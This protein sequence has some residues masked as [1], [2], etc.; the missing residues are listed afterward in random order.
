M[1]EDDDALLQDEPLRVLLTAAE[2][3]IW[4]DPRAG[5]DA[6]TQAVERARELSQPAVEARARFW[7]AWC[8]WNLS[9]HPECLREARET[10]KAF[11]ELDHHE[12]QAESLNLLGNIYWQLADYAEALDFYDGAKELF[13][14]I[15]NALGQVK[16]LRNIAQVEI[17]LDDLPSA[18]ARARQARTAAESLNDERYLIAALNI[19]AQSLIEL[20][21]GQGGARPMDTH[22]T[23]IEA[24]RTLATRALALSRQS[25]NRVWES[26]CLMILAK[27]ERV[28][29]RLAQALATAQAGLEVAEGVG[30]RHLQ[31][32]AFITIG[33]LQ[34]LMG[35]TETGIATL[36]RAI[37]IADE[38]QAKDQVSRICRILSE[39]YERAGQPTEALAYSRRHAT[40]QQLVYNEGAQRRA[41]N[42][43]E[44]RRSEELLR[45]KLRYREQ[46]RQRE[47]ELAHSARLAVAGEMVSWI[48]H[49]LNQPH[50]AILSYSQ[51]GIG[52]IAQERP[53]LDKIA[54]LFKS[55]ETQATRADEVIARLRRFLAKHPPMIEDVDLSRLAVEALA[56]AEPVLARHHVKATAFDGAGIRARADHVLTLQVLLNL[57]RNAADAMAEVPEER[58]R[59]DINLG[60]DEGLARIA[61]S[62]GGPGIPDAE[63][64]KIFQPFHTTKPQG[65]GLGLSLSRSIIAS[66][67]GD[68]A[69]KNQPGGGAVFEVTLPLAND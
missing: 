29:H 62:D 43:A 26:D 28:T 55:I 49:E 20:A 68:I 48:T 18:V 51:T 1:F 15:G 25:E 61:V 60:R 8:H 16:V 38:L 50:Q 37:T 54:H 30:H 47:T 63:M 58:R 36:K 45:D 12:G 19:E 14:R 33:E 27:V 64:N 46:M 31:S 13:E 67:G 2:S 23:D 42:L 57:V 32:Y 11:R 10:L 66:L 65:M 40:L 41:R 9:H 59:L 35:E 21:D 56:L 44:R 39:Q 69:A 52:L 22:A 5:L 17:E 7:L 34:C 6:A 3:N 53:D 24:A 4:K